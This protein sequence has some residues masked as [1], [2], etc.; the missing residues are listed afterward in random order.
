MKKIID[1]IVFGL[2]VTLT[3]LHAGELSPAQQ[4]RAYEQCMN[5]CARSMEKSFFAEAL[6]DKPFVHQAYCSCYCAR[7]ALRLTSEQ[8][9]VMARDAVNK[10]DMFFSAETRSLAQRAAEH[11]FEPLISR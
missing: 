5:P 8:L 11:C 4:G 7:I 2:A 10:G 9:A 6:G 3:A 1:L